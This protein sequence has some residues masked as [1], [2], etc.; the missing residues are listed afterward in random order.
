MS[1]CKWLRTAF[2]LMLAGRASCQFGLVSL[3]QAENGAQA[4]EAKVRAVARPQQLRIA[5]LHDPDRQ[6][7]VNR[8]GRNYW[9]VYLREILDQ[10][11]LRAEQ[12][13]PEV[14]QDAK[15][16][17]RFA[18]LLIGDAP[19]LP[20]SARANLD[21]WLRDGG[22]LISF[23]TE[24][25]YDL[26]GNRHLGTVRQPGDEFTCAAT[27]A[28]QSHALTRAIHSPLQPEQR[29]LIFSPVQKVQPAQSVELARL[30]D[31]NGQDT[32]CAAVT[33][34]ELSK[35]RAFYF[36]FSVPQTIWVLHQGRPVDRD[37]DG[38][39]RLRSSDAIVIR[40]HSIEVAYADEILFLLQNLIGTQPHPFLHQLPPTPP[41]EQGEQRAGE[42]PDALFHWGGDD[43]GS[44][45]GIQL[46]ASNWMKERGLPYH[47]NA[48]P[49][50]DGTFGLS[51][52]DAQKIRANGHEIS[53]HYNFVDGFE[54]A[55]AFT[56]DDVL[57]QAAAFRR[58]FGTDFT[59]SVNHHTRWTG[60]AEPAKWMREAGGKADNTMVHAGSPPLNPVN[61]LGFSFGT[62]FPFWFYDD[63]RGGNQKLDFLE[64]PI[65]AYECG[66][67]G[68]KQADFATVRKVIDL[69]S[70]YH[71][72]MNM[73]HHPIYITDYPPCRAA[74]EEGLRYIRTQ[75]IRALHMGND[76]LYRWWKARSET[77]V[78]SVTVEGKELSFEV[79]S[80]H[81]AGVIVKVPL[82]R[83]TAKAVTINGVPSTLGF[84][85]EQRFGQNWALMATPSGQNRLKVVV[86]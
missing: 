28:L 39:G 25:V 50:K 61:L 81:A 76:E 33:A 13:L 32:G 69:A 75:N 42:I 22:T 37:Y 43:E 45:D 23:A 67:I 3:Q 84:K 29:L 54:G 85:N 72:T 30:Y 59:C 8:A 2:V 80:S 34:R 64:M 16:L 40:P 41:S 51:V 86:E 47:I 26:C 9:N 53:L 17:A 60:W 38:D 14:L 36:A 31:Q 20:I 79:E 56:R 65:T 27:F 70:H 74:I 24:G 57:A 12:V 18:T 62:S 19:D 52:A 15:R 71:L 63:G 78:D 83:R 49:R 58:H 21:R 7:A 10:L 5:Y 6:A 66:Y 68:K 46:F 82:G 44:A 55:A 77:R 4:A 1:M 73:F 11:G 48:M 35:G